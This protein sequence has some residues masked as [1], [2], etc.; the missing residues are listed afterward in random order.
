MRRIC[1]SGIDMT[2][3]QIKMK[4]RVF[5]GTRQRSEI[6]IILADVQNGRQCRSRK[7]ERIVLI[8]G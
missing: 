3:R 2:R 8:R 6:H 1:V 7:K 5:P 4:V